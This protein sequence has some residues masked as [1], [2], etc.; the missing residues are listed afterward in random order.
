MVLILKEIEDTYLRLDL[1]IAELIS[2][3]DNKMGKGNYTLFLT[4]D[5]AVAPVPAYLKSLKI[6]AGY[7]DLCSFRSM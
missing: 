1:D 7:F 6:P 2:Y 5:H 3:L 4:A